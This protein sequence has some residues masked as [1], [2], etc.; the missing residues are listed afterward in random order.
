MQ[1]CGIFHHLDSGSAFLT[2]FRANIT[3]Y[4]YRQ[5][6][7]RIVSSVGLSKGGKKKANKGKYAPLSKC[8][9]APAGLKLFPGLFV[10]DDTYNSSDVFYLDMVADD[11]QILALTTV[12]V[13]EEYT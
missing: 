5:S 3:F 4:V 7:A 12:Y 13:E 11:L 8:L 2:W 9:C 1:G 6:C 10:Y